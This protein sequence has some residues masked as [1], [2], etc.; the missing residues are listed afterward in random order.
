MWIAV[1]ALALFAIMACANP[2]G[3]SEA[4]P[5]PP[6]GMFAT[7]PIT[8]PP[9]AGD[10]PPTVELNTPGPPDT[11]TPTPTP[12]PTPE[13]TPTATPTPNPAPEPTPNPAPEP[14]PNPAPEP[15]PNPAPKP[16]ILAR[17]L[18][19][20]PTS[21]PAPE[22]T[23]SPVPEPTS[24]PVPEPTTAPAPTVTPVDAPGAPSGLSA[25]ADGETEID[26]SWGS[27]S[28]DGGSRI[29]GYRI[30]VS[31]DGSNWR[32]LEADT[33]STSTRYTHS[34]LTGGSTRYYR[35][36]AINSR[37]VSPA[38]NSANATT[39]S[40]D[41][42]G[43]PSGL[44]ATADGETEIDLSW[45]SPSSDGGSRITGYRIEVSEDGSNWRDLEADTRSTSTRYTHSRL[46]GG[47][48][49]YYRVSAINS[50]GVSPASNSANATTDSV[51]APGAPSGLSATADGETEIDLSWGSPSSD[52]GSRITGYRIE[53]SEDGSN[54][55]DL[56]A[57]TRSTS[58]RYT[59]SRL[60]GGS[61]RYYRVSAINSRG[62][63]PA[64]NSA[65]ATTD[66]VDA[67]GA[68][69]GLSATAD[70]ETEIDLSWGSPSSDG[71]SRITGYRIEVS[72][73]GSNWRDLEADTR[74][75][76]TRYTHSRLTGGS[77]RYYR[78]SAINSRGVSPA[79]N[80]ANATTDSVDAPGAPSGL[81]ATADGETEI[82]LSW[83][84]PSSDGGSRIT[85]Y[86]IEVSEDG[87]N[88][89]DLEAD[90]R[91]TSTRYTHSRL[92]GGSTRYYTGRQ[93][94]IELRQRTLPERRVV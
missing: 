71:G 29:T 11:P 53:V 83:G 94:S 15:T 47:S 40:V 14:T 31:E 87:S 70:G 36:S 34:R 62:V 54:W 18:S 8:E 32:D 91:S 1:G 73:D 72:E 21:S 6:P 76:S 78:V 61:T 85:G 26:L 86:R 42:P 80:S 12:E 65:N 92:T 28:S 56:E 57:D 24:S 79:S 27:P 84:S 81:S 2:A 39:D 13:P 51:D 17:H 4:S 60:T 66:S 93:P 38:S 22:P 25:T 37:G 67:P 16:Y 59:H 45:G 43:A 30:E 3:E 10:L 9:V 55:R 23:S 82:D 19:P 68:P 77:T 33:R 52:G 74:S 7:I 50:R 49:R 5:T 44:S 88:W 48:T 20:K 46:T 63:S 64:S 35:V 41:A 89:R 75:T 69:S 90:T 58:T